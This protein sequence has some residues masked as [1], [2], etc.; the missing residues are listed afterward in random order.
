MENK[1]QNND[2]LTKKGEF[3][4]I[5]YTGYVNGNIFDTNDEENLKKLDPKVKP[6]KRVVL[7]GERM[8]VQGLDRALE[9]KKTGEEYEIEVKAKEGFGERDKNLIKTVPLKAFTEKE[10]NPRVGMI[11]NLDNAL[12]KVIAV[13]GARVIIDLN[14]PLAGKDIKYKFRII[15]N[16][17]D[18]KIKAESLFEFYMR[19][20]PEFEIKGKE[21]VINAPKQME[22]FIEPIERK[23][24]EIL[25][26]SIKIEE[27]V[28]KNKEKSD[29]EKVI[30]QK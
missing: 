27:K 9:G 19:F 12:A 13:S 18:E 6:K 5:I 14:N 11:L 4:E 25:G 8:V 3:F 23:F 28:D 17:D 2:K 24:K 30:E 16:V 20:V 29:S 7:I 26:K 21:I 22:M 15:G 10:V 1:E